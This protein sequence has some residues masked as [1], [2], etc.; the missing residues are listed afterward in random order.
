[1]IVMSEILMVIHNP[2]TRKGMVTQITSIMISA[3]W[4]QPRTPPSRR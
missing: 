4:Y 1:M 2:S 3:P